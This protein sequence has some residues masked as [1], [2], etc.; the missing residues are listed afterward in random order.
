MRD[1]LTENDFKKLEEYLRK[2]DPMYDKKAE[3]GKLLLISREEMTDEEL[4]KFNELV[5]LLHGEKNG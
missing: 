3:L 5:K 2:K 4:E 1:S